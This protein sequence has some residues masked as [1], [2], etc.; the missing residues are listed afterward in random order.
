MARLGVSKKK[1]S[2][3]VTELSELKKELQRVTEQL[4]SCQRELETS[5][6]ELRESLEQQTAT[7]EVLKVIAVQPSILSRC[8]KHSPKTPRDC[9]TRTD[10]I[11][12]V[13]G[14][15]RPACY[16]VSGRN[17]GSKKAL[18]PLRSGRHRRGPSCRIPSTFTTF[19]ADPE[20]T[21]APAPHM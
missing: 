5:N 1:K 13:D 7:S 6:S 14:D 11:H 21:W 18:L 17:A 16:H 20:T 4:K 10:V 2:P 12:R 9:A 15:S 8:W 3:R 19:C